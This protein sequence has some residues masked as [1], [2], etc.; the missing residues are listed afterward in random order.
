MA[1]ILYGNSNGL[2]FNVVLWFL[3]CLF[4]T[5]LV[6]WVFTHFIKDSSRILFGLLGLS[7]IS[8]LLSLLFPG[9][10]LPFGIE[11][12]LTAVVFYGFGYL[13][14]VEGQKVIAKIHIPSYALI[15][16]ALC[17]LIVFASINFNLYGYQIDMRLNRYSNY[18][19]FYIAAIS[20]ISAVVLGSIALKKND[21]LEKIGKYSLPLFV[22]HMI[23]FTYLTQITRVFISSETFT[24]YRTFV[25]A[26][27]FTV[28]TTMFILGVMYLIDLAKTKFIK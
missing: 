24:Q 21:I 20:G 12:A 5:R 23:V 4:V 28:C 15:G 16:L 1:G 18:V 3:P 7:I 19:F 25:I 13:W 2:F 14:N 9:I 17:V 10:K 6:F 22:W 26:P 8:Y 27:I 11:T